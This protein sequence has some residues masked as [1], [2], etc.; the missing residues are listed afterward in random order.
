MLAVGGS[1]HPAFVD[2]MFGES[3][4]YDSHPPERVVTMLGQVGFEP[5]IAE[6]MNE[7]TAERDKGRYAIVARRTPGEG[8]RP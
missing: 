1:D 3:F 2:T 8:G 7:P 5:V 6:F 4:F